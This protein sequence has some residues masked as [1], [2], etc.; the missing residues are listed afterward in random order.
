MRPLVT[1]RAQQVAEIVKSG[2]DPE[3][4]LKTYVKIQH[5]EKGVIPFETYE[6]QDDCLRAFEANRFNIVLKS[7]QL[8]LSTITAG[9]ALWMALFHKDKSILV[10]ATKLPTALNFIKKVRVMLESIPQWLV[11]G[12][13][14]DIKKQD[15]EFSNG[16]V[17]KA[18]PTSDDAGRSESLSLLI[19]DEAAFVRDFEEIW[20][21]LYPTLS[22]GGR[23][24]LLSTPNGVGGQ[25]YKL[26]TEAEAGTN[27]F[28][29]I[30]LP[31]HVH[32]EHDKEWFDKETKNL[33]RRQ[34][35]Q[36]MLCDFVS[37][38]ETFL[39]NEEMEHL[40]SMILAPEKSEINRNLWIWQDP[41]PN[42]KYV[43][44]ADVGRGDSSGNGD[45]SACHIIDIEEANVVG[46]FMGKLPPDKL[47]DLMFQIGTLY[48]T[49][50]LVPEN[51][52]YGWTTAMRLRDMGYSLLFNDK[53]K[54]DPW[55][56]RN[57][58][59]DE[60]SKPGFS[61]QT[62][63]RNNILLRLEE[64]IRT[65]QLSIYSQRLYDQFQ[66]FVW[67]NGKARAL[68][69]CHDDLVLSLAIGAWFIEGVSVPVKRATDMSLAMM[70]ATKVVKRGNDIVLGEVNGIRPP[71]KGP[72]PGV[73]PMRPHDPRHARGVN[74]D[75]RWLYK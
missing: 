38:G 10:I 29:T 4:F 45:Y 49:A 66:G 15:I 13:K 20:T 43:I 14:P 72:I 11:L 12:G 27:S 31:W 7:R 59:W 33:S 40:R 74:I 34:V 52:S 47:A 5:P 61:T 8:G 17:I 23:A 24:I 58:I 75:Y 32:P 19:V 44:S 18:I 36:E 39:Q 53:M 42:R 70:K 62:T 25:Y 22:A 69:D 3:Y 73:H 35:A 30:K 67:Q 65:R 21:G 26:W 51:N 41:I 56:P 37:S 63:S 55:D 1:T 46:E 6:F 54:G 9:Y 68:R 50:L 57:A 28:N 71:G 60:D 48:N 2:K 16:S 64:L